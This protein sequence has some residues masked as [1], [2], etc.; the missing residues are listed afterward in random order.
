MMK[1]HE[2]MNSHR[3]VSK[4]KRVGRGP[5]SGLGK[6]SGRGEKGEGSRS[7]YKRRYG[8]EGGGMP[9]YKKLPTKGFSH[10]RFKKPLDTVNLYQIDAMFNDGDV[11]SESTLREKGFINGPSHGIKIL[12]DG[13]L[14]KKVSIEAKSFSRSAIEKLEK[15]SI[16]YTQL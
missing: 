3:P 10:V 6:T 12:A 4:R 2:L 13:E 16:S 9:L 5:G 15:L 1:L 14:T 11:V 8:F 7:G